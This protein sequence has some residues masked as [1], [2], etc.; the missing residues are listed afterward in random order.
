MIKVIADERGGILG[1]HILGHQAS[2]ML[3]EVTLAMKHKIGLSQLAS[4]LHAYPTYP[5]AIKHI[6]DARRRAKF[7]GFA[8]QAARWLVRR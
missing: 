8:R 1:A 2:S 5:E 4:V 7:S 3:G 6:A